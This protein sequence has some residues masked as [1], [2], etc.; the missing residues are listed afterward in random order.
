MRVEL[1][2]INEFSGTKFWGIRVFEEGERV[3]NFNITLNS[4][5]SIGVAKTLH[6]G[7]KVV[8]WLNSSEGQLWLKERIIEPKYTSLGAFL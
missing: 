1:D 2:S 3:G 4:M 7:K 6:S 5:K 8:A